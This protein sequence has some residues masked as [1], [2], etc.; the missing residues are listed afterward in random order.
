M[1]TL[2]KRVKRFDEE[3]APPF[4]NISIAKLKNLR[5]KRFEVILLTITISS[6][7]R[8]D[9]H[10]FS[11]DLYLYKKI[12]RFVELINDDQK[13]LLSIHLVL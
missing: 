12:I 6:I 1:P 10:N 2:R 3:V 4:V 9:F 13:V 8:F 11:D 5:L 7:C